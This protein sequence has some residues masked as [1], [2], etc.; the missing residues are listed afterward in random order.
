[1][2]PIVRC[3]G[4]VKLFR[5]KGVEVF[6]LQ[7][8]DLEVV[9]GEMLSILGA[10]GSGKSTLLSILGGLD[11]P[12]AGA[13]QVLGW[14]LAKLAPSRRPAYRRAVTGFLWQNTVLNL[15][16]YLTVREN[17][18]LA[19]SLVGRPDP[20]YTEQ[21][22]RLVDIAHQADR[23]PTTMSGGEQQRAAVAVSLAG[24]QPILLADEPTGS[25][26]TASAEVV[27]Q[28][29]RRAVTE[30]GT[31]V[32]LV[33]HDEELA[34]LAN[35][36]I[37]IRDGKVAAEGRA[38]AGELSVLDSAGRIQLPRPWLE[39]AGI[40]RYATVTFKDEGILVQ[41]PGGEGHGPVDSA[42]RG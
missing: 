26:D 34:C 32:I 30:L 12:S 9:P 16:P 33:T 38:G 2:E 7:G 4:L 23:L 24:R 13:V 36:T 19:M 37:R 14:D 1:M 20:G 28:A 39:A 11:G 31:T 5:A 29:L 42:D 35:R 18:L 25:L 21:L 41:G 10:S 3:E 8:L 22:L 6:A 15:V 40:S 17:L 27:M